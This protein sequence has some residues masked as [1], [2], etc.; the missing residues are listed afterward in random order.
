MLTK[1]GAH[2]VRCGLDWRARDTFLC[3]RCLADPDA[4][5]EAELALRL[6]PSDPRSYAIAAFH[7]AG[8]WRVRGLDRTRR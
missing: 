1:I 5:R 7:W 3:E 8:G 4:K 2:C 6:A